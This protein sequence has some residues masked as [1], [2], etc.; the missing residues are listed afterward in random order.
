MALDGFTDA[1]LVKELAR[2]KAEQIKL[3]RQER[4][5]RSVFLYNNL[6]ELESLANYSGHD[7]EKLGSF[8]RDVRENGDWDFDYDVE[9]RLVKYPTLD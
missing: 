9:L 4:N 8:L 1:D 3:E 6:M 5:H 2:R 7:N